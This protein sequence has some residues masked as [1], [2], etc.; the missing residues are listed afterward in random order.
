MVQEKA[1]IA[2]SAVKQSSPKDTKQGQS[3]LHNL[4]NSFIDAEN[5]VLGGR[6]TI[7]GLPR[8]ARNDKEQARRPAPH[9]WRYKYRHG[10]RRYKTKAVAIKQKLV[11]QKLLSLQDL[12]ADAFVGED[13]EQQ[14][15]SDSAVDNVSFAAA[16]IEC[17]QAR[18]N[19]G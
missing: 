11:L 1:L 7:S 10:G 2:S 5:V 8:C 14:R 17:S 15:V 6:E 9:N 4:K 13:L 18:L 16:G 3:R 19:F 12:R